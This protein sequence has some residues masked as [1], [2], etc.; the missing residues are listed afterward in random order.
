MYR[1]KLHNVCFNVEVT[2]SGA[3]TLKEAEVKILSNEVCESMHNTTG[4]LH[5]DQMCA[6]YPEGKKGPFSGDSGGPLQ[7]LS[8]SGRWQLT[9]VAIWGNTNVVKPAIYT[10]ISAVL[11]WIMSYVEGI[12]LFI[13]C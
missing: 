1:L 2:S 11:D 9:G 5:N 8:P 3:D 7:C 6:G 12:H 10:R 4:F 13:I